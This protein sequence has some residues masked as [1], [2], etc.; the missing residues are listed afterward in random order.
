MDRKSDPFIHPYHSECKFGK[1]PMDLASYTWLFIQ[2][3]IILRS[4]T[5]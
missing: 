1:N 2:I 3:L 4:V 5:P